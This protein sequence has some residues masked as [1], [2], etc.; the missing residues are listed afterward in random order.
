MGNEVDRGNGQMKRE[1]SMYPYQSDEPVDAIR[2][3]Y[4]HKPK[5]SSISA[6]TGSPQ[7][8]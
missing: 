8:Q 2:Y 3:Q 6:M 4:F 1:I 5:L 7:V